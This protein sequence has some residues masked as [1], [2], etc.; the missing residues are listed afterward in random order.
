M[1]L[2]LVSMYLSLEST[3]TGVTELAVS[4]CCH[5]QAESQVELYLEERE[6]QGASGARTALRWFFR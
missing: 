6:R 3:C 1:H 2:I 4:H 5:R